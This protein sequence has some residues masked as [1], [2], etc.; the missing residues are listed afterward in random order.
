M[1]ERKLFPDAIQLLKELITIPSFSREEE[2]SA[3]QI[4]QFL[5][6]K[7]INTFRCGNNVFAFN[8]YF[9]DAKP[10]IILNSHHDT[11]KP[12][13]AYTKNPFEPIL[14]DGRLYGLGSTD[15][16]GSL[17][18]LIACFIIINYHQSKNL[19]YNVVL[20]ATAEEEVSGENGIVLV[21]RDPDFQKALHKNSF[22][23]IGEPTGLDLAIAEKGLMVL[24]CE[25]KGRAGHA[26]RDEGVNAIY[27]AMKLIN[28]FQTFGFE[29][30]SDFLGPVKMTVT[31][32][33]TQ[34]K[35]HNIIPASCNFVVD[36]RSNELY[37]NEEILSI[38]N[39]EAMR[40]FPPGEVVIKARS[41]RLR[42]TMIDEHHPVVIAGKSLGKKVYGS[43]TLSDK[44]L[45][46]IPA[47]KCGPGNSAQSHSADEFININDI[48][49]GISFYIELI[50]KVNKSFKA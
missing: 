38:I 4:E 15:A 7:E 2:H 10:S 26:A 42:S 41:L 35:S 1:D 13:S 32:L 43:P 23:I 27:K 24:D 11:V 9:N 47:L 3:A 48:K 22:A 21:L 40:I 34:N 44:A 50:E 49:E 30:V 5:S 14:E 12:N 29:K 19:E 39:D 16:G 33:E 28:W 8:K 17:V 37:S 20:A 31:S 18:S 46:G 25:V 6:A 45:V 36:V